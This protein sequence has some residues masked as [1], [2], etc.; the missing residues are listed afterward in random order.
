MLACAWSSRRD[1]QHREIGEEAR[2]RSA[3]ASG[4]LVTC[5]TRG[6]EAK[7]DVTRMVN[8]IPLKRKA[9]WLYDTDSP[10]FNAV[11]ERERE[12]LRTA[13]PDPELDAF[14][15]AAARDIDDALDGR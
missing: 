5:R 6:R 13:K 10:E 1:T 14:L 3:Q 9:V 8:G 7:R 12:L 11:W 15:E 4:C 2:Y